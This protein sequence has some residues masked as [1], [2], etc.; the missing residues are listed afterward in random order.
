MKKYEGKKVWFT[1]DLH[2]KHKNIIKYCKR[3]FENV[4]DMTEE[5]IAIWN[6]TVAKED[7]VFIL[8]DFCF[9]GYARW[10]EILKQLNGEIHLVLG[11]HDPEKIANKLLEK[12]YLKSVSSM[13]LIEV[14]GQELFLC[15]FPMMDWPNKERG[16]IMLHGHIHLMYGDTDLSENHYDVGVDHNDYEPVCLSEI[17]ANM[18]NYKTP[19]VTFKQV[20]QTIGNYFKELYNNWCVS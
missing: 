2:F 17:C 9:G 14:D 13:E 15:H 20:L 11:N 8:G 4:D 12:G 18:K 16:S 3:P 1:S 5:L 7:V 19:H 6:E 10:E